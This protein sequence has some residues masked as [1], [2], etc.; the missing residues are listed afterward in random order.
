M[1]ARVMRL[2]A[3][4]AGQG[5]GMRWSELAVDG[6]FYDQAHLHRETRELFGASPSTMVAPSANPVAQGFR[7]LSRK[8]SV[9]TTI[10]R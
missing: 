9:S 3:A 8:A 6:G 4:L 1:F 2:Q 7:N 5:D 10:F